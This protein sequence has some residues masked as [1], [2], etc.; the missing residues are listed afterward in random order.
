LYRWSTVI[1]GNL[2]SQD[3]R[4]FDDDFSFLMTQYTV[5]K[6]ADPVTDPREAEAEHRKQEEVLKR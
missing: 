2:Y 5:D 6:V 3:L 4:R 1:Y